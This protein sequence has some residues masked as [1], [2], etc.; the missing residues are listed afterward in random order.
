MPLKHRTVDSVHVVTLGEQLGLEAS[1]ETREELNTFL[2]DAES[3]GL[4]L[5]CSELNYITSSGIGL[6]AD[7]YKQLKAQGRGFALVQV[8]EQVHEIL[9]ICGFSRFIKIHETEDQ[10]I[11][12]FKSSGAA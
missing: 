5:D 1:R 6:V 2:E 8:G 10:A 9:D 3:T 12:D 11:W 7:C 4:I